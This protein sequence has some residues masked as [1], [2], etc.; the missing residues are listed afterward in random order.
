MAITNFLMSPRDARAKARDDMRKEPTEQ[1]IAANKA[2]REAEQAE[3]KLMKQTMFLYMLFW[4][5]MLSFWNKCDAPMFQSLLLGVITWFAAN[6][7]G[8]DA[9]FQAF[10]TFTTFLPFGLIKAFFIGVCQTMTALNGQ[11]LPANIVMRGFVTGP[12]KIWVRHMDENAVKTFI[13]AMTPK[14]PTPQRRRKI[15]KGWKL[16]KGQQPQCNSICLK[17]VSDWNSTYGSSSVKGTKRKSIV[18][19]YTTPNKKKK[20]RHD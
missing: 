4:S 19:G 5:S 10:K 18:A 3:N 6:V 2:A 7:D 16:R 15:R 14:N 17:C 11:G 8:Q 12:L 1:E 9:Q 13:K 20:A